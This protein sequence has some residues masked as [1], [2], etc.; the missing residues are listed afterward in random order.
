LFLF[1]LICLFSL[2]CGTRSESKERRGTL[3]EV[4]YDEN[5]SEQNWPHNFRRI[6]L[7]RSLN[8]FKSSCDSSDE[9]SSA[10][11]CLKVLVP[12]GLWSTSPGFGLL[13]VAV[14][15]R[16][17]A[18]S[19]AAFFLSSTSS[20]NGGGGTCSID[21][22]APLGAPLVVS[23]EYPGDL[24]MLEVFLRSH[25]FGLLLIVSGEWALTLA[26][27]CVG[28]PPPRFHGSPTSPTS[29]DPEVSCVFL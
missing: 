7:A 15:V 1:I 24:A 26:L 21:A 16:S 22:P 3:K 10:N 5:E 23:V 29:P 28:L 8:T 25:L 17:L 4:I 11:D 18:P 27:V 2:D 9:E 6:L 14:A 13:F 19:F 20:C 12:A